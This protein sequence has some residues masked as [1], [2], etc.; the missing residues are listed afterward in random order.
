VCLRFGQSRHNAA[1]VLKGDKGLEA[2]RAADEQARRLRVN[3]VPFSRFALPGA[4]Q[5]DAFIEAFVAK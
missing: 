5:P 1:N 4:Q 2:I 3:G